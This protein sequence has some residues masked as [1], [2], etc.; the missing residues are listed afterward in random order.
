IFAARIFIDESKDT[1]PQRLD[2]PGLL[3]SAIALFA[4]TFGLIESNGRGWG[5]PVVL[6]LIGIA[7][8]FFVIFIQLELHQRLPML[9][10]RLFR[11]A[12]FASANAV[13]FLIGLAMFGTFFFVSL[14]VQNI[15]GYSPVQAGATFL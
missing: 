5:D 3:T 13:M 7:I 2:I 15:L 14:Y 6:G 4:L 12:S 1:T 9:D 10:L 8:V 11:N